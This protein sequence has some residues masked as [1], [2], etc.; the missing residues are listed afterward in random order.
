MDRRNFVK[1]VALAPLAVGTFHPAVATPIADSES[2]PAATAT[3][4]H[5]RYQLTL[6]RVLSGNS[7]AYTEEFLLEDV[8]PIAGRR[9][10]EYSGD[11]S[12]RYIGALATAA[13]VYRTPFPNLDALVAKV[14]ALQKPDGYFGS[15]FHYEKP[16]DLDMALLWG[17][18]RLLVGLIEYY[19]LSPSPEVLTS[20]KRLGDFLV[21]VGPL[22]LSK[23][24]RDQF[25]AQH[26][27][28]SYICWTQQVEGLANLYQ[29]TVDPRYRDLAQ[30]IIAV[31]DRRPSDHVHGYLTSLR[32]WVDLYNATSD[33]DLL[34][35]CE[36]A[37][38]DVAQSQ[39]LLI[40]GGVP[41]GWSPNNHRTEGCAEVDWA[42]LSL[43]LWKATGKPQYLAMAERTVFNELAFNQYATG[44]FGHRVYTETGLAAAGAVRAWW[45]CT[46]HGL[47]VF[48]D[49][50]SSAFRSHQAGL[51]FDLPVD[52]LMESASL[53]ARSESTLAQDG[54]IRITILSAPA[55]QTPILI[56]KPDW[57][58]N[59][60]IRINAVAANATAEAG[61]LRVL[62]TW[63]TGDVIS[64]R[65]GM[66]LRSEPAGKG[67]TA[68]F[69]GPWLLGAPAS[70]NPAYFNELTLNNR[71]TQAPPETP[72]SS[73]ASISAT[74]FT[75]PVAATLLRY[76]PAEF[77]EQPGI[78]AFRAIAEQTGQT[79]TSWELRF[80]TQSKA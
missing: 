20:C 8:R 65:Y 22:M 10:T 9:F 78:V 32:G 23:D 14:I 75:V 50:Q 43:A 41:E 33:P 34:R 31:T 55:A 1:S 21:R 25:G 48:P 42:R 37:W 77:P 44:D 4:V 16:T 80:L 2:A 11:V 24:T 40:T 71:L 73:H 69:F 72:A 60:E 5:D 15:A 76:I 26:F 30:A 3:P 54:T 35:K 74:S 66:A 51:S 17:N 7:P 68:Y 29:L 12:G 27:A 45:C 18:G 13:R 59:L 19:R 63:R 61:Y 46:L 64:V 67:R 57:A 49:V 62:R 6:Q 79:T 56:R 36:A 70:E 53:S 28:S 52:G 39:D 58:E 47:R 38:Q